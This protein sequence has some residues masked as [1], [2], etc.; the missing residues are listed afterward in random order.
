MGHRMPVEDKSRKAQNGKYDQ[1]E[2]PM[3]I[4]TVASMA[5][6]QLLDLSCVYAPTP[7]ITDP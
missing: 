3:L 4:G 7:P 1:P 5:V 6:Q 2:V